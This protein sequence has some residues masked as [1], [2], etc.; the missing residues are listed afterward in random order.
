M[1]GFESSMSP[2]E[3]PP[4]IKTIKMLFSL[5]LLNVWQYHCMSIGVKCEMKI[6][7]CT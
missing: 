4:A 6:S 1:K 5:K 7:K 3:K 2:C